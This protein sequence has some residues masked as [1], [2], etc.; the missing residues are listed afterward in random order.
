MT[1]TVVIVADI[2]DSY[3]GLK[4]FYKQEWESKDSIRYLQS[5]IEN[6]GFQTIV[7]EPKSGM[8]KILN[9]LKKITNEIRFGKRRRMDTILFNLVEGFSSRNREGYIPSI[10]EFL[11]IPHTGSDAYAQSVSL[12]KNLCKS[13]AEKLGIPVKPHIVIRKR[14]DLSHIKLDRTKL[15]KPNLEG[16][17][18]SISE[19]NILNHRNDLKKIESCL[20][21]HSE[22]L[23][24]EYLPGEEYTLGVIGI[25]G[26]Y[27]P[28]KAAN[29]IFPGS[30]YGY[31]VKKKSDMPEKLEFNVDLGTEKK[32]QEY[33]IR[34]SEEIGVSGYARFDYRC[35]KSGKP[36]FLEANLTCGL[37]YKYST[38][39]LCYTHSFQ[40]K[41]SDMV[42]EI[43]D[44]ALEEF[45]N[46]RFSYGKFSSGQ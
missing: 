14:D 31:K 46:P 2:H 36:N 10:A 24:E 32:L 20:D 7:L 11:G 37:S 15:W 45:K 29:L 8:E 44:F 25:R 22:I 41:Y 34:I 39:P 27:K 42:Q 28:T 40:K 19:K 9:Y 33:S 4:S 26:K 17:G 35:D 21:K 3:Q 1:K 23:I 43:L 30:V 12:D 13:I 16:S 5:T 18:I 6:L 38:F